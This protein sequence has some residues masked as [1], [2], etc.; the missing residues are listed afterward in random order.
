MY[1]RLVLTY[2]QSIPPGRMQ[3]VYNVLEKKV[4]IH[5]HV[6]HNTFATPTLFRLMSPHRTH[7]W[8]TQVALTPLNSSQIIP[9]RPLPVLN[10]LSGTSPEVPA[11]TYSTLSLASYITHPLL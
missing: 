5:T 1:E 8:K 3:W 9:H 2:I 7:I 11:I 10:I 6:H 4:H